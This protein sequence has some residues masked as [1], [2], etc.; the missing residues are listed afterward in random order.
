M[1]YTH[2]VK[3]YPMTN[4][5]DIMFQRIQ[6][7]LQENTSQLHFSLLDYSVPTCLGLCKEDIL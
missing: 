6:R 4:V 5:N 3:H 1:K 7:T 2:G